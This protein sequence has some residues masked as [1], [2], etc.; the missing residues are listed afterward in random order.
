M[1]WEEY[2]S[3]FEAQ[4]KRLIVLVKENMTSML[5]LNNQQEWLDGEIELLGYVDLSTNE[6][7]EGCGKL[8]WPVFEDEQ[9]AFSRFEGESVYLVEARQW[10][11]NGPQI[12]DVFG[13]SVHDKNEFYVTGIIEKNYKHAGLEALLREY[14]K[15][16]TIEDSQI[17]TLT[18]NRS[19]E[20]FEGKFVWGEETIELILDV[21]L[22]NKSSLTKAKKYMKQFVNNL[23]DWDQEMRKEADMKLLEKAKE[24]SE[25]GM[26]QES[27]IFSRVCL[28][29]ISM[30]AS[31]KFTAI[32]D[33]DNIFAGH[34]I[35]IDGSVQKG[36]KD[37][38]F[39]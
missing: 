8:V 32:Y 36:I 4:T 24:W 39:Q 21:Q 31:G 15:P 6:L 1:K 5:C 10:C 19:A 33:D 20:C 25:D 11:G 17:G 7:V 22:S 29:S 3:N 27:E 37:V 30:T 34:N 14:Q 35:W 12:E 2:E 18:Y 23:D 38:S 16:M 28:R 13:F 9:K 26:L